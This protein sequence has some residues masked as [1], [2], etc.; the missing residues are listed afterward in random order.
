LPLQFSRTTRSLASNS[1]RPALVAWVV[2]FACL[3]AWLWWFA[4]GGVTVYEISRKAR[5]E[6]KQSPHPVAP[7]MAG[8]LAVSNLVMGGMV[9][10]GDLLVELDSGP[11][12]LRLQEE[13]VRLETYPSK[14]A[15]LYKE[16]EALQSA[17]VADQRSAE[18]A[19]QSA[20]AR[21]R[22]AGVAVDFAQDNERRLS[23]ESKAGGVAQIDALRA[24]S[25]SRKLDAARDA[26]TVDV[27]RVEL[28]AR[29]R[30]Q[31]SQ[32]QIE[33][34][35]RT[36][37]SLAGEMSTVQAT[38]SRLRLEIERHRV[39]AP[40]DGRVGD[41]LQLKP[42]TYVAEGQRLATIIPGGE[43]VV[44][45]ELNPATALGRVRTG[46]SARLRLDGFPWAQYGT[47][48]ARVLRVAGEVRE[49]ALRVELSVV[50]N[51]ELGA[52]MQHGMPGSVEIAI[53]RVAP[54]VLVLRAAGQL[55]A[56]APRPVTSGS[57]Q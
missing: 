28:D 42:G 9:K 11:D 26:L 16:I 14:V 24:Q 27:R 5:L 18:A 31:Q 46:Q 22:E 13:E 55:G 35:R 7:P 12:R 34:L 45:A 40:V 21:A 52:L 38:V 10:A 2:A 43:L 23:E 47:L 25:E 3:G 48:E 29:T 30:A 44:I 36:A 15:A 57:S 37:V 17:V 51:P 19:A 56:G 33:N 41:V 53:E 39:R 20:R 32:V 50:P 6:V 8:K 54:A 49:N 4:F 1:S